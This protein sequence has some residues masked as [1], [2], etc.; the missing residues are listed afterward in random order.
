MP[1]HNIVSGDTLWGIVKKNYNL[2][3]NTDIANMV[4]KVAK[5]NGISNPDKIY[6]GKTIQ[7]VDV[8]EKNEDTFVR[9]INDESTSQGGAV[10]NVSNPMSSK[11]DKTQ[12]TAKEENNNNTE[13]SPTVQKAIDE[14][15][16]SKDLKSYEDI[17]KAENTTVNLFAQNAT[18]EEKEKAYTDFSNGILKSYNADGDGTVTVEEFAQK[19]YADNIKASELTVDAFGG[20]VSEQNKLASQ[21]LGNIFAQN[22]DINQNGKIDTEEMNF[23]NKTADAMDGQQDGQISTAYEKVLFSSI[24]GTNVDNKELQA[25]TEKYFEGIQLTDEEQKIF[26]EGMKTINKSMRDMSGID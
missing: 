13:V 18:D 15:L 10:K 24:I 22:L 19:E 26:D 14:K 4:N 1:V 21:R 20:E 23:F 6:A 9:T 3:N 12:V 8:Q 16:A 11:D 17:N 7:L 5:A 25:V 2:T